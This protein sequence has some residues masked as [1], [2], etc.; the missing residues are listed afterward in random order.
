MR[1]SCSPNTPLRSSI[2][3]S[4]SLLHLPPEVGQTRPQVIKG[5]GEMVLQ[6]EPLWAELGGGE[7]TRAPREHLIQLFLQ[8]TAAA[9]NTTTQ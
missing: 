3:F 6:K 9:W 5:G 7:V 1:T 4:T 2:L 8:H